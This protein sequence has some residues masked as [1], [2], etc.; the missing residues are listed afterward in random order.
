MQEEKKNVSTVKFLRAF[1][2][3]ITGGEFFNP[4]DDTTDQRA[5]INDPEQLYN[6]FVVPAGVLDELDS[7]T[8][9]DFDNDIDDYED[10]TD[11][12]VDIATMDELQ[13]RRKN[14]TADDEKKMSELDNIKMKKKQTDELEKV[15]PDDDE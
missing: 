10:R 8:L 11:L 1:G 2:E 6:Q 12:G 4:E 3:K 9:E 13:R 14:L 5:P 15:N 7:E